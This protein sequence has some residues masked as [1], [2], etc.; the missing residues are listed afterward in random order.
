MV[1]DGYAADVGAFGTANGMER[2][3][4]TNVT[5]CLL[6]VQSAST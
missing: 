3:H 4:L 1:C 6:K 2:K 5:I